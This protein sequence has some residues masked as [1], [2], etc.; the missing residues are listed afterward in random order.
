VR[1]AVW[2]LWGALLWTLSAG[3]PLVA[4][5]LENTLLRAAMLSGPVALSSARDVLGPMVSVSRLHVVGLS[6]ALVSAIALR[7]GT[8]PLPWHGH[9]W[10]EILAP[11]VVSEPEVDWYSNG[12]GVWM[13]TFHVLRPDVEWAI[14]T[15][16][17]VAG[18]LSVM[19]TWLVA[20]LVWAEAGAALTAAWVVALG[21]LVVRLDASESMRPVASLFSLVAIAG[22]LGHARTGSANLLLMQRVS[23][24]LAGRAAY[25]TLGPLTRREQLGLGRAGI[26]GELLATPVAKWP[27]LV[28]AQPAGETDWKA[29]VRRGGYPTPA[30]E[31]HDDEARVVWFQGYVQTYLERDLRSLAAIENLVDFRRLMRLASLRVG[32]VVN[33]AELARDA[34]IP[35]PT[36]HR[37][38]NLLE[39]SFLA[40]RLEPYGANRTTRLVKSPKLYWNDT[41]LAMHLAGE[42]A[43]RGEHLEN[44]VASD[45]LAWKASR[46]DDVQVLF[47][48]THEGAEV[49]FVIEH[50]DRLLAIEVKAASRVRS[51][52]LRHLRAFAEAYGKK[53]VGSVVLHDGTAVEWVA[54]GVLAAPWWA[55]C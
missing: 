50:G 39:T 20:R 1:I 23:E 43:A 44:L 6:A 17:R 22:V 10:L 52:D 14:F 37:Y 35:R 53:V 38:L 12:F 16:S 45:L 4:A 28:R 33:Q 48:R 41:A 42:T 15:G 24:S 34:G 9:D 18:T 36:V 5:L 2:T 11:R 13:R 51:D 40:V 25:V 7:W 27:E 32:T 19:A 3:P 46:P 21:P 47:W 30:H 8:E 49:D 31:L 26:W 29:L 55:V 54:P